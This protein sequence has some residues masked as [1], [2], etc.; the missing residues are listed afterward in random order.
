MSIAIVPLIIFAASQIGTPG[1]ANMA[2]LTSGAQ[3]GLRRSIPF[4]AG[5]ALGK[6]LIIWPIGLGLLGIGAN[7]PAALNILKWLSLAVI[8]WLAWRIA[9]MRLQPGSETGRPFTFFLGLLVHPFNP[10]A[11]AMIIAAFT[12]FIGSETDPI[13]ATCVVAATLLGLQ[14]IL[15]PI[16]AWG[17]ERIAAVVAGTA[18]ERGLMIFLAALTVASVIYALFLGEGS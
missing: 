8:L 9:W 10:K 6:Q 14:V 15:H 13:W 2:L 1:P 3:F 12:T 16:W 17:G 5:V 11:W 4:I 7:I 18:A